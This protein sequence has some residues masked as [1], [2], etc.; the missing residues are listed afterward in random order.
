MFFYYGQKSLLYS[1]ISRGDM[2]SMFKEIHSLVFQKR[3]VIF[4]IAGIITGFVISLF[5]TRYIPEL[6]HSSF[7]GILLCNTS[8]VI[9]A[10]ALIHLRF[11]AILLGYVSAKSALLSFAFFS[12]CKFYGSSAWLMCLLI[13]FSAICS[14]IIFIL[15]CFTF[16]RR[17]SILKSQRIW[18]LL[19]PCVLF[20]IVDYFLILPFYN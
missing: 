2:M 14:N 8:P 18:L 7:W 12:L 13:L 6:S 4:W 3:V 9:I 11:H 1:S 5:Q 19:I 17:C 16:P 20:S 15:A 10:L